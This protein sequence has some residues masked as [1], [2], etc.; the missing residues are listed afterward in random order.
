MDGNI[1]KECINC[2][3]ELQYGR[4]KYVKIWFEDKEKCLTI[5]AWY[6]PKCDMIMEVE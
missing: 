4:N 6:C 1:A 5:E 3:T 2:G